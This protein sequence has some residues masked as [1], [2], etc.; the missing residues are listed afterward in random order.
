M[1][2]YSNAILLC[3]DIVKIVICCTLYSVYVRL[4]TFDNEIWKAF[5]NSFFNNS[6]NT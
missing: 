1:E 3:I 2:Y 4:D 6:T 5:E